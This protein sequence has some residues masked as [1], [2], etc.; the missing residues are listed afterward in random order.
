MNSTPINIT[1]D[2]QAR[3][4]TIIWTDGHVSSYEFGLLRA[5][6]PCAEC[7]GGHENM[8]TEPDP[9]V[10]TTPLPDSPATRL[11]QVEAVGRYALS[12]HWE[13]GHRF[14]IY[15]WAYLRALCPCP[16]C[17]PDLHHERSAE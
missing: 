11:S 2:R 14:G 4:M 10:F 16:H 1:A 7:R 12:L 9:A 13:D 15:T 17:Q 3:K 6:C 5:A 8:T